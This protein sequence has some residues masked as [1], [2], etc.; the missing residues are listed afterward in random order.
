MTRK[1]AAVILLA[2]IGAPLLAGCQTPQGAPAGGAYSPYDSR[3]SGTCGAVGSCA[4][5]NT[6]PYAMQGNY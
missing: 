5:A 6:A 1:F 3:T 4:P 2:I